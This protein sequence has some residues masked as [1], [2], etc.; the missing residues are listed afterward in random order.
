MAKL[1]FDVVMT[2]A[3]SMVSLILLKQLLGILNF[4]IPTVEGFT[5]AMI[6]ASFL[7]LDSW[8]KRSR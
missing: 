1:K 2:V 5:I 4:V 7:P 8:G 3:L 6:L